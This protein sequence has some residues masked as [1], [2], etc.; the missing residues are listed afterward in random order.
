MQSNW[1][2]FLKCAVYLSGCIILGDY[3]LQNQ[4]L[5]FLFATVWIS[6]QTAL[7]D[8]IF[9]IYSQ[10][11]RINILQVQ[12]LLQG[13]HGG[14]LDNKHMIIADFLYPDLISSFLDHVSFIS[15]P[16]LQSPAWEFVSHTET[17]AGYFT[18]T[19]SAVCLVALSLT[20]HRWQM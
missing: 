17:P 2:I 5:T 19:K 20:A 14:F 7:M 6:L 16:T 1:Q 9:H 13:L 18:A 15:P 3:T 11:I 10:A 12:L 4:T 8:L